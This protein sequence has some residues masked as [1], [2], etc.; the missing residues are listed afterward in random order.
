MG[1]QARRRAASVGAAALRSMGWAARHRVAVAVAGA[2][3]AA[4]ACVLAA[5]I[6]PDAAEALPVVPV[7]LAA[8]AAL[9]AGVDFLFGVD[10]T[11]SDW[12][13]DAA[14]G[15]LSFS[16]AAL[17]E[18]SGAEMLTSTWGEIYPYVEPVV[19]AVHSGI[20]IPIAN[21][22][23]AVCLLVGLGRV[24]S[25][26]GQAEAGVDLWQI[27]MVFVVFTFAKTIIDAS[28]E[29]LAALYNIAAAATAAI[30]E[31]AGSAAAITEIEGIGED[32]TGAGFLLLAVIACFFIMLV[33]LFAGLV[34]QVVAMVRIIQIY[35]YTAFAAIPLAFLVSESSRQIATGFVKKYLALLLAGLIMMFLMTAYAALVGSVLAATSAP[36]DFESG[37]AYLLELCFSLAAPIVY[38]VCM[39]KSGGWAREILGAQ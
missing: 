27:A 17:N 26:L 38:A 37:I 3:V 4:T 2:L 12:L 18:S 7:V 16:A 15:M 24:V 32:V 5:V 25:R 31:A 35:T 19:Y 28:Y 8:G 11:V 36:T 20:C 30:P 34:V 1:G 10:E 29:L 6:A 33:S 13:R 14:N 9:Y 21:V 39:V 23:L 22:V